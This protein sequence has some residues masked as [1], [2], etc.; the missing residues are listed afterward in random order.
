MYNFTRDDDDIPEGDSPLAE[1]MMVPVFHRQ[2]KKH[3][4]LMGL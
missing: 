1:K 3:L 2:V 4:Q